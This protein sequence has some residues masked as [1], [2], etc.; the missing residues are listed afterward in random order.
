MP[1]RGHLSI[2]LY[3]LSSLPSLTTHS[4]LST[5]WQ[6]PSLGPMGPAISLPP[7][8]PACQ[9]RLGRGLLL[10]SGWCPEPHLCCTCIPDATSGAPWSISALGLKRKRLV[11]TGEEHSAFSTQGV[12]P[13]SLAGSLEVRARLEQERRLRDWGLH[14]WVHLVSLGVWGRSSPRYAGSRVYVHFC[15]ACPSIPGC[16][17]PYVSAYL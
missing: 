15:L 7:P 1:E 14:P 5:S 11:R 4:I 13:P 6:I 8:H 16:L 3:S 12:H 9:S 10:R 17:C 2:C